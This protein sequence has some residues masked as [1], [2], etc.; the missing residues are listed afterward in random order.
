MWPCHDTRQIMWPCLDTRIR[1]LCI[2]LDQSS[3]L[4]SLCIVWNYG[5]R[6]TEKGVGIFNSYIGQEVN[7]LIDFH[8]SMHERDGS[9]AAKQ[10]F[11]VLQPCFEPPA[12]GYFPSLRTILE[13]FGHVDEDLG[14]SF[15]DERLE[16]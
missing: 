12:G 3:K 13:T 10:L 4:L 1:G 9:V 14:I 15:Y 7:N 16:S 8:F 5:C 6:A 11:N 2:T